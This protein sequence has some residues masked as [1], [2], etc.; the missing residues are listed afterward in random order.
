MDILY[1]EKV[2]KFYVGSCV[3]LARRLYEHNI[4]HSKFTRT[5]MPWILVHSEEFE[6]T[7]EA[8][9]REREVMARKSRIYFEAL[10]KVR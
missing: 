7:L 2:N 5:G 3:N 9:R 8:H 10:I 4:G 6:S 1:S